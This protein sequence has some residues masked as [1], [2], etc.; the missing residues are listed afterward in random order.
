MDRV[1][2]SVVKALE[3]ILQ[4]PFVMVKRSS[5]VFSIGYNP[6]KMDLYVVFARDYSIYKYANIPE[7]VWNTLE[8]IAKDPMQSF[9]K[10]FQ[11]LII[12]PQYPYIRCELS[13][14]SAKSKKST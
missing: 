5:R 3:R 11:K 14:S 4:L 13:S 8:S 7:D 10:N 2:N 9:G 6:K 1:K 12:E